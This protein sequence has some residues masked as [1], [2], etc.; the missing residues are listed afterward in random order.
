MATMI[1]GVQ[2]PH[3]DPCISTIAFWIGWRL[4][5]LTLPIPSIVVIWQP[6]AAKAG[7]RQALTAIC[8]SSP[9]SASNLEILWC[10]PIPPKGILL[11]SLV[12]NKLK[13][14]ILLIF[15]SHFWCMAKRDFSQLL[16]TE[17]HITLQAPHPPSAHPN[18]DPLRFKSSRRNDKR[19]WFDLTFLAIR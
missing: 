16:M 18:F 17:T 2:N 3:W 9:D 4:S 1:P 11:E 12:V 6:S 7:M 15:Y 14:I 10:A 8:L 5:P 19:V 13:G